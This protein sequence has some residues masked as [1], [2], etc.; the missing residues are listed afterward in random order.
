[1]RFDWDA[2]KAAS[3]KT[4]HGVAFADAITAFD[5][6]YALIERDE[7]HSTASESREL[8]IGEAETGVLVV[9]FTVREAGSVYRIIS[10]R[11][12]NRKERR[13]YEEAKRVPL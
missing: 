10:A 9:I 1:M 5:D 7:A 6:P 4:K 3:N 8:L 11:R 2:K 13:L 12:A